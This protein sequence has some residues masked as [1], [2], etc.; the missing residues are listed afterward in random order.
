MQFRWERY[1]VPLAHIFLSYS[2][3]AAT[4]RGSFGEH[5]IWQ[6][7]SQNRISEIKFGDL[8]AQCHRYTLSCIELY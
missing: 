5:Y 8:N 4:F 6:N 7:D 1:T 2:H 3:A